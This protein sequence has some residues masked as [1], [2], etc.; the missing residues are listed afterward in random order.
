MSAPNAS[1]NTQTRSPGR[2]HGG[3][4]WR[5]REITIAALLETDTIAEAAARIG[6]NVSTLRRWL[7]DP[8]FAKQYA[9]ARRALL[10]SAVTKL[11]RLAASAVDVLQEVAS[12]KEAPHAARVSAA[13]RLLDAAMRFAAYEELKS[14]VDALER[15]KEARAS[16]RR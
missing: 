16:C 7:S 2:G 1:R 8:A 3:K 5:K 13:A 12:T 14:R 11:R 4:W 9:T 10:D 15:E 6:I